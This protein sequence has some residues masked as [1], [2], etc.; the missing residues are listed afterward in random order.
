M[1]SVQSSSRLLRV[2]VCVC[3]C[4]CGSVVC[5]SLQS[6]GLYPTRLLC[7]W[8]FQAR[9][10]EWVAISF[11]DG[12]FPT[13]GSNSGLLHCRK[14]L[15]HLSYLGNPKVS[16]ADCKKPYWNK[17]DVDIGKEAGDPQ[18]NGGRQGPS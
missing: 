5:D 14:I 7:P 3:V 2:C 10:L 13:Q 17:K 11:S 18:V 6:Y 15:Y 8:I 1:L 12:I 4:V 9:I 16:V